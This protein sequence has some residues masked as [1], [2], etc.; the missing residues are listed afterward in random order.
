MVMIHNKRKKDWSDQEWLGPYQIMRRLKKDNYLIKIGNMY[1]ELNIQNININNYNLR[2]YK[3][4][5][6]VNKY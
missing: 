1:K 3:T 2:C 4:T 5:H 6:L